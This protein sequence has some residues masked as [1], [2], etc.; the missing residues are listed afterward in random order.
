M[1]IDIKSPFDQKMIDTIELCDESE[2]ELKL[3]RAKKLNENFPHGIEAEKRIMHL[4]KLAYLLE[5]KAEEFAILATQEGGKPITD[6]RGEIQ[7]AINGI[8]LC[9]EFLESEKPE[10]IPMNLNKASA[11]RTA[12]TIGEPIGVVVAI[13]AFNHPVNLI[14]HQVITAYTAGCPVIVKPDLRTPLSCKK[15]I[16]LAD[17]AGFEKDWC[18]LALCD[19][20]LA[21]KLATDSR[22]DYLNFIGSAKVGWYLKSKLAP[23]TRCALEHGGIAASII[24]ENVTIEK[25]I[26]Q[27]LKGSFYHAGQVC[28]STQRIFIPKSIS[29]K[30]I[31]AFVEGTKKLN[32]SNPLLDKTEVGPII[33]AKELNRIHQIIMQA[34]E[35]GATILTGGHAVSESLYAPTIL[36]NPKFSS[37]IS[38]EEIFGPVVC[39]YEYE[40]IHDAIQSI[41]QT[42]YHFQASVFSNDI[43]EAEKISRK[44]KASAVM[45]N[46]H[47]AFRVDWMPFAGHKLSGLGTGGIAYTINEMLKK[48]LIVINQN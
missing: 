33:N 39:I 5:T 4:K 20:T 22:V 38:K 45:I 7:R 23:G 17:E 3:Q 32:V 48:K 12:Y 36:L 2:I 10:H 40:D 14:V 47:T 43:H 27:L 16:Q 9:A 19:N 34:K 24:T 41:N 31:S 29:Q 35:D 21:E 6:S 42:D 37:N 25:I 30:F 18:Q 26:P 15:L 44:I 1:K 8:Q 13:S 46:D 28:V 11:N